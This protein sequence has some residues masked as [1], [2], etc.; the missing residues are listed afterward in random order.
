M[1]D[2]LKTIDE[3]INIFECMKENGLSV[4]VSGAAEL[5]GSSTNYYEALKALRD[6]V[7]RLREQVQDTSK[8]TQIINEKPPENQG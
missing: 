5:L 2:H 1:T 6:E 7:V 8:H 3:L 4:E